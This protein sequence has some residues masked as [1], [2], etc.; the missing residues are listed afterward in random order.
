MTSA[1]RGWLFAG[2]IAIG[3]A[4][5]PSNAPAV[6]AAP[7]PAPPR[8]KL[9]VLPVDGA[10]FPGIARS[11]NNVLHDV[12]VKGVDDYFLSKAT[13]EV[14]QLSIEC[15]EPTSACYQAVGKQLGANKLLLGHI[16]AAGKKKRDKSVRV[17]I[18]L[19]DVDAGEP[20]N[21][22]DH[23]YRNPEAASAG[24]IDLVAEATGEP[25]HYY[26]PDEEPAGKGAK[27]S[28]ARGDKRAVQR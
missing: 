24:T 13:L 5:A 25:P 6:Q 7:P 22:V 9:A 1:H 16:A 21:V 2:L 23:V 11:L 12:K 27:G 4:H 14:V 8:L 28:V 15:V 3:C 17:T 18:T 19:F 20:T 10:D 26:G